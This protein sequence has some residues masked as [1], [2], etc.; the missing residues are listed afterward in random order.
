MLTYILFGS[1]HNNKNNN[2]N[3]AISCVYIERISPEP[4]WGYEWICW[5]CIR[6]SARTSTVRF[7]LW[8]HRAVWPLCVLRV[9][10]GYD[11]SCARCWMGKCRWHWQINWHLWHYLRKMM[12]FYCHA[13]WQ[14]YRCTHTHFKFWV[15]EKGLQ[16]RFFLLPWGLSNMNM[17]YLVFFSSDRIERMKRTMGAWWK[18]VT[19]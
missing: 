5:I 13:F 9:D 1:S 17:K 18:I 6:I 4:D 2:N 14:E 10:E 7:R 8:S 11:T 16:I 3:I 19:S 12:S 15:A